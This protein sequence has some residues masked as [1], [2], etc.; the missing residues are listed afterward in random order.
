ME[1][2]IESCVPFMLEAGTFTDADQARA[3]MRAFFPTLQRW[4][5][6]E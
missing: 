2:M 3:A 6:T 1:E 5:E 4:R